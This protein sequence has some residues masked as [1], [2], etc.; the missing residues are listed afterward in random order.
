VL[1]DFQLRRCAVFRK[2]GRR[3]P[4]NAAALDPRNTISALA[5]RRPDTP[6]AFCY[7]GNGAPA[8]FREFPSVK[9]KQSLPRLATH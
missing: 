5:W 6:A 2:A 4:P 8:L 1:G 9:R 7:L 3:I